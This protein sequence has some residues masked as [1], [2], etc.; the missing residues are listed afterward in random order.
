[1]VGSRGEAAAAGELWQMVGAVEFDGSISRIGEKPQA[2]DED[3]VDDGAD[4]GNDGDTNGDDDGTGDARIG[5][6]EAMLC[7]FVSDGR[8]DGTGVKKFDDSRV[9]SK[10][11][12]PACVSVV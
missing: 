2:G 9:V 11:I 10:V 3:C 7:I 12:W 5:V 4:E 6:S 8:V 1:M